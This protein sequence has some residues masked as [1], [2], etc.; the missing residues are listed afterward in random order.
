MLIAWTNTVMGVNMS[1]NQLV[2][3]HL[4]PEG[5]LEFQP[6]GNLL[7]AAGVP[8]LCLC[9][10]AGLVAGGR[11]AGSRS[12]SLLSWDTLPGIAHLG[13][14]WQLHIAGFL[15]EC[16]S[17]FAFAIRVASECNVAA[18]VAPFLQSCLL[19]ELGENSESR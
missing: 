3:S 15:T 17:Q 11:G 9:V 10:S 5:R 12:C 18:G 13:D 14:V 7:S 2:V 4:I 6:P 1:G 8:Q 19:L 16:S